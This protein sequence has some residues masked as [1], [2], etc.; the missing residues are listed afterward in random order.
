[1]RNGVWVCWE[2]GKRFETF[3][4]LLRHRWVH[5][6]CELNRK[7]VLVQVKRGVWK[8][9]NCGAIRYCA[10]AKHIREQYGEDMCKKCANYEICYDN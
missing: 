4:E 7:H 8:C 2:C 1:M 3:E 5:A 6:L 9:P 10:G